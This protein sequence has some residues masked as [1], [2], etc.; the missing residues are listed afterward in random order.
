MSMADD[1]LE[2]H[3]MLANL[4]RTGLTRLGVMPWVDE[5]MA[6]LQG[7][8][9]FPGHV[10]ARPRAG[11]WNNAMVDVMAA[12]H[13]LDFAK[14]LT[15]LATDYFGEAAHLWSLNAFY[16]DAKT[17]YIGSVNGMHRDREADKILTLFMLGSDTE[18]TGAQILVGKSEQDAALIYGKAGTCW[19]AD[20]RHWHCGLL[21][22]QPRCL[23]WA[24]WA[25]VVPMAAAAEQLPEVA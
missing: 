25:N 6:H 7:C 12:P 9:R 23:A 13:F 1:L 3:I 18:I 17:P 5:F 22:L 20:T 10:R 8:E 16:T 21:P 15:P 11:I 14:S 4:R 24:R 2:Q 19:L